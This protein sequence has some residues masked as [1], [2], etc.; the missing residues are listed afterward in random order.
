MLSTADGVDAYLSNPKAKGEYRNYRNVTIK[1]AGSPC[2]YA[3]LPPPPAR[4]KPAQPCGV[5]GSAP[6]SA[7]QLE[8]TT[9]PTC[10][11]IT[12][13]PSDSVLLFTSPYF[14]VKGPK[15]L[16]VSGKIYQVR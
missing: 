6:C 13:K 16:D 12:L 2:S 14:R 11:S 9:P 15:E 1:P 10:G 4:A 3:T 8:P 5:S 7:T